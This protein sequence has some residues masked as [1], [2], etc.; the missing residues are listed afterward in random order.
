M[1]GWLLV[2]SAGLTDEEVLAKWVGIA[3]EYACSLPKK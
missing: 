2:D 1:R 3:M